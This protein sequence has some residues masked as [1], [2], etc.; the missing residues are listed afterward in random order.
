LQL[1]WT[2]ADWWGLEV[3]FWIEPLLLIC[4]LLVD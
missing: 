1:L 2:P 4:I 3:L